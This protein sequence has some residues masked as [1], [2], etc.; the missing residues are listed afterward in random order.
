MSGIL[1]L[2]V[3][4]CI[5]LTTPLGLGVDAARSA[6]GVVSPLSTVDVESFKS[7][8]AGKG[9]AFLFQLQTIVFDYWW[10][11]ALVCVETAVMLL[12]TYLN[13]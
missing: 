5:L 2:R 13:Y 12:L 11:V 1:L 10:S 4:V 6:A 3:R 8:V 9:D 7:N